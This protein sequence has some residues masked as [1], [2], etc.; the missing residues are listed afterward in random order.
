MSSSASAS[1]APLTRKVCAVSQSDVVKVN[2]AGVH[3]TSGSPVAF[4]RIVTLTVPAGS[5][6]SFTETSPAVPSAIVSVAGETMNASSSSSST[7]AVNVSPGA[8]S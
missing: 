5:L 1:S 8:P 2:I 4:L 7:F 3:V 6:A